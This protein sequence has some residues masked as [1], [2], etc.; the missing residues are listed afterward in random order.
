M[1]AQTLVKEHQIESLD[2]LHAYGQL[3]MDTLEKMA[4]LSLLHARNT[5]D[6]HAER[7]HTMISGERPTPLQVDNAVSILQSAMQVFT[8]SYEKWVELLEAQLQTMQRT[9]HATYKDLQRWSPAG[10]E[11]MVEAAELMTKAV[12]DSTELAAEAGAAMLKNLNQS[13][14]T[15]ETK[16]PARRRT[17]AVRKTA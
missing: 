2:H 8:N 3:S 14:S 17:T 1:I 12:E 13:A 15:E 9:A 16:P 4:Q 10:T 5:V 11:V 7:A 6:T